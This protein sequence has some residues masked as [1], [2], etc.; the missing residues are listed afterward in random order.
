MYSLSLHIN[1]DELALHGPGAINPLHG[2]SRLPGQRLSNDHMLEQMEL[3][4][5]G[6]PGQNRAWLARLQSFLQR[7]RNGMP[8]VLTLQS[9]LRDFPY[10]SRVYGGEFQWIRGSLQPQGFGLRLQLERDD[11]WEAPLRALPLSNRY[12]SAVVSGLRVDNRADLNGQNDVNWLAE[13]VKGEMPAPAQLVLEHSLAEESEFQN[14]YAGLLR[15]IQAPLASLE[16][17]HAQCG[18]VNSIVSDPNC[19]GGAYRQVEWQGVDARELMRWSFQEV[20]SGSSLGLAIRPFLRVPVPL[21][22]AQDIW[23]RWVITQGGTVYQSQWQ[24]VLPGQ[25]LQALP[26]LQLPAPCSGF[27][28]AVDYEV[29]LW[30]R[31]DLDCVHTLAVDSVFLLGLDGWRHFQPVVNGCL[32]FGK[33][34]LDFSGDDQVLVVDNVTQGIARTYASHGAGLWIYPWE[35]QRLHLIADNGS[36]MPLDASLLVKIYYRPRVRML[37]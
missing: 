18:L 26:L 31:S 11:F 4:L 23:L 16:G 17:E 21:S 36:L 32:G 6:T 8:A 19:Q 15:A 28:H 33:S 20:F 27:E 5:E 24:N 10:E 29:A 25:Q 14:I 35:D 3:T 22:T 34:L 2:C 37:L 9:E 13:E 7:I 12:G 1:N 30:A